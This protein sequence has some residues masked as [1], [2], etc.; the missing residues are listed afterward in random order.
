MAK[1]R[2]LIPK[3]VEFRV[4]SRDHLVAFCDYIRSE[5]QLSEHTCAAY[6]RDLAVFYDWL[7]NRSIPELQITDLSDYVT[8]LH[9]RRLAPST[10]SRYVVSLRVF[11]RYLQMRGI[12]QNNQAELLGNQ[13]IWE[14]IPHVLT[15]IQVDKLLS[16][17]NPERD[18]L[19][20]RDRAILE[21]FYATGA[22][23]S[24]IT[25]LTLQDIHLKEKTCRLHGKGDKQREVPIGDQ[26]VA[27]FERWLGEGR[28]DL[29]D[30][31][32]RRRRRLTAAG[33]PLLEPHPAI[34]E[35]AF[36]SRRGYP[37]RR[38]ALWELV[39]KYAF[40]IG[41][42][43]EISPHCL[44][45]SF[46]THLLSHGADLRQV[47]TLLGHASITTT[48]IYTHVDLT[49]LKAIHGQFHPRG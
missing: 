2:H 23:A 46:A 48:E 44:R 10:L 8:F 18:P 47:Q 12:L 34:E 39:K 21:I 49:Q 45:H 20:I 43:P 30:K 25:G 22:R 4:T 1:R 11:F 36:L 15:P 32:A 40:R 42:S 7:E 6:R 13:R 31:I 16:E 28:R 38:E 26:A 17:P 29:L 41:A 33:L 5:C 3:Q 19:W 14:R 35:L 27:V 37:L 9:K 24:E